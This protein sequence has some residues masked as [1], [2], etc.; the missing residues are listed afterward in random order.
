MLIGID[1]MLDDGHLHANRD[2]DQCLS[3][4]SRAIAED[5]TVLLKKKS[6]EQENVEL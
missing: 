3:P 2:D 4:S 1:S 5:V 6:E